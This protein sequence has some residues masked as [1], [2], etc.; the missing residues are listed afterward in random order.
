MTTNTSRTLKYLRLNL[1]WDAD[2]VERW[3]PFGREEKED[4]ENEGDGEE[5]KKGNKKK[6]TGYRKDLFGIIDIIALSG[7]SIVGVQSCGQ[8]FAEHDRKILES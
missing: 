7:K 8:S 3:I 6:R 2:I 1:G 4:N 5:K